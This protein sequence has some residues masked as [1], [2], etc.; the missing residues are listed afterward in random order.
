[1]TP[2]SPASFAFI[3]LSCLEQINVS[4]KDLLGSILKV[5]GHHVNLLG[6]L[7][8]CYQQRDSTLEQD[9][10]RNRLI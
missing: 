2:V 8:H 6:Q 7:E 5:D 4:L 10:L 1:M 9:S 3:H